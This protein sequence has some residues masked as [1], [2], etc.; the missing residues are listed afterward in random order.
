MYIYI[1]IYTYS[2]YIY[3]YM[4]IILGGGKSD[5]SGSGSGSR[6]TLGRLGRKLPG[7]IIVAGEAYIYIYIYICIY[8]YIYELRRGNSLQKSLCPVVICPYLYRSDSSRKGSD[9]RAN[10]R[11]RA[12]PGMAPERLTHVGFRSIVFIISEY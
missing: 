5:W 6:G 4:Y 12:R 11:G 10:N 8:I 7:L 9:N 2:T 3:I 1:Y